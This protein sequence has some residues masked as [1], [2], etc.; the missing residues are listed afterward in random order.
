MSEEYLESMNKFYLSPIFL[1]LTINMSLFMFF[2]PEILELYASSETLI[3][4]FLISSALLGSCFVITVFLFLPFHRKYNILFQHHQK[5]YD[6]SFNILP[7]K[8]FGSHTYKMTRKDSGGLRGY[9]PGGHPLD[10]IIDTHRKEVE[11]SSCGEVLRSE[12]LRDWKPYSYTE[13]REAFYLFGIPIRR[14][15]IDIEGVCEDH[16]EGKIFEPV[17]LED[18]HLR[19]ASIK[20]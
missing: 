17:S 1:T 12:S 19:G 16:Y 15:I 7:R 5:N 4:R 6:V 3:E 18:T 9:T 20:I 11:C 10:S 14:K 8:W 13:T 2:N